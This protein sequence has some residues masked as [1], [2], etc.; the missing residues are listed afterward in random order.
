[1]LSI[2][3]ELVQAI[4]YMHSQ[5]I[6]HRDIKLENVM[7]A[8]ASRMTGVKLCDFGL[9]AQLTKSVQKQADSK[10]TTQIS[11]VKKTSPATSEYDCL[12]SECGSLLYVS[13]NER[14][15][16]LLRPMTH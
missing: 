2:F 1:M 6:T 7:F 14:H 15:T 13:L 10:Q 12:K 11:Y 16:K 4:S 5:A 9:A 8:S 3:Q